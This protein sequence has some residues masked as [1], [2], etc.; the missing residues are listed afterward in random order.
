MEIDKGDMDVGD[1]GDMG[2]M[3]NVLGST[4]LLLRRLCVGALEAGFILAACPQEDGRLDVFVL[5]PS[6]AGVRTAHYLLSPT[7]TC[8]DTFLQRLPHIT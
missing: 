2:D 7:L 3:G 4:Q 8:V 1:M 6:V 5:V